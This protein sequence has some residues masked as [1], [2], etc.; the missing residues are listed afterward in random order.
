[1]TYHCLFFILTLKNYSKTN[2]EKEFYK[3][4]KINIYL[5]DNQICFPNSQTFQK[6]IDYHSSN[7]NNQWLISKHL[8]LQTN[9]F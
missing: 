4:T 8:N 6:K 2:F 3:D 7:F 1:M 5:Y 9:L